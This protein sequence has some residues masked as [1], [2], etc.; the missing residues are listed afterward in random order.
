MNGTMEKTRARRLSTSLATNLAAG[1][2]MGLAI[3]IAPSASAQ[4]VGI[5]AALRNDVQLKTAATPH[6]AALKERVS[7]GNDV[8]T[9]SASMA[10]L[11]LLD[12]TTFS[13]GA[14]ARVRIDRF[15]YD[16]DRSASAVSASVVTGAFRFM[17]SRALHANPGQSS[18]HTPVATIGIRGTMVDG[19]VGPEAIRIAAHESGISVPASADPAT[20]TLIILRGP[21]PHA[22]GQEAAGAIDITAGGITVSLDQPGMAVFFPGVGQAPSAPFSVSDRGGR[23]IGQSLRGQ[24][25][26]SPFSP[27]QVD[28]GTNRQFECDGAAKGQG[29][30]IIPRFG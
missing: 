13:V 19:V 2:A 7:L 27:L 11:L 18:I 20:A 22:Q 1:L 30:C 26:P 6:K 29:A 4:T 9:G 16:P 25:Q 28:P 24:P 15:V 17:S 10:Q 8:L 23:A 12:Q 21:G 14:N 3:L 5:T